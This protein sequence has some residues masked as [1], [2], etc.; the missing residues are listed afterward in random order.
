MID[1]PLECDRITYDLHVSSLEYPTEEDFR[2][3]VSDRNAFEN[4]SRSTHLN[5]SSYDTYK[6]YYLVVNVF[7]PYLHYTEITVTPKTSLI[8]LVASVGGSLG[9]FLGF[10]I[11][12]LIEIVEMGALMMH[13]FISS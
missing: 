9:I 13:A 6:K 12:S 1:C 2:L 11:F 4:F 8:E 5:M 10:S 3:F 7:Y